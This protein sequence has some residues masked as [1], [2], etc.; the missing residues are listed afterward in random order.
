MAIRVAS[1]L[2]EDYL[3]PNVDVRFAEISH[4]V[5]IL[6]EKRADVVVI[7]L[8]RRSSIVEP[9]LKCHRTAYEVFGGFV[10]DFVRVHLYQRLSQFIPS[11]T[12]EGAD[13]LF[14]ILQRNRELFRYE[15]SELGD[16]EPLLADYLSGN[17]TLGDVLKDAKNAVRPQT[18]TVRSDQVGS[19][20][21]A[22]PDV[23]ESPTP[24]PQEG[25]EY[26]AAPSILR[27]DVSCDLKI[28]V[29]GKKYAQLNGVELFL[30]VSDR[31]VK[32]EGEFFKAPHTT[33]VIWA[34]HRVI[35]IF[36]HASGKLTLYYDIELREQLTEPSAQGVMVPTTTVI[37]KNRIY[38]P[39]P[40]PL[41]P[42]FRISEGAKEFYVRFDTIRS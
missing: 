1:T 10:K 15:E 5:T 31:L 33:K 25:R 17:K 41:V 2:S 35:Y 16:L 11:S 28:L 32:L 3:L 19:V 29:T 34:S 30:A 27:P 6:V 26:E 39:V 7:L 12:R 21:Q 18:V 4:G 22:I 42:D 24:D 23:G 20:E 37:T 38:I 14:K 8:A 36:G 13:A 40:S 9:V